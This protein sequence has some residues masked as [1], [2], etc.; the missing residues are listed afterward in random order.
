V[1]LTGCTCREP[2]LTSGIDSATIFHF[3]PKRDAR[4]RFTY[5]QAFAIARESAAADEK[6]DETGKSYFWTQQ[7]PV[8]ARALV[9]NKDSLFVGGPPDIFE[10]NEPINALEGNKGGLL[11]VLSALDGKKLAQYHLESPPVFDGMA[12]AGGRLYMAATDGS[13]LCLGQGK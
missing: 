5:Y 9:L 7:L 12:A 10:S 3:N 2:Y 11:C 6:A 4:H 13:V 8:L 1:S